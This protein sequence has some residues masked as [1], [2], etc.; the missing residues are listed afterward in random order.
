M[1]RESEREASDTGACRTEDTKKKCWKGMAADKRG[2]RT[3]KR[4]ET[5]TEK[6]ERLEHRYKMVC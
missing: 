5:K 4:R 2:A 3:T 1:K 6:R